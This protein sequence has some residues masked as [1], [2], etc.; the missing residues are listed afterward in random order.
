MIKI[1]ILGIIDS[2]KDKDKTFLK[3]FLS[4]LL[5]P[6]FLYKNNFFKKN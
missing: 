4:F 3:Y 1:T 2:I 6:I 5:M